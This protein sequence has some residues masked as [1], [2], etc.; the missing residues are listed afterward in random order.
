VFRVLDPI[1]GFAVTR[2]HRADNPVSRLSKAEKPK[3]KNL[4]P[5]RVLSAKE[6]TGLIHFALPT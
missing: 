1:L 6:I 4:N 5:A 3:R 2:G